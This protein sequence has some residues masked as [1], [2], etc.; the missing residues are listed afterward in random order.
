LCEV[1]ARLRAAVRDGDTVAR[2]GGDEFAII[3]AGLDLHSS[4][5]NLARRVVHRLSAPYVIRGIELAV[6]ASVGVAFGAGHDVDSCNV[7]L[8]LG[9]ADHA[10]YRAKREGR[11]TWRTYEPDSPHTTHEMDRR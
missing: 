4:A 9:Q 11:C 5:E 10:L 2:M 6:G 7:D 1:A 3:Q 8:L